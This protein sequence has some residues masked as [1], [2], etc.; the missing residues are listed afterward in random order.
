MAP[1][2]R[3]LREDVDVSYVDDEGYLV[4]AGVPDQTSREEADAWLAAVRSGVD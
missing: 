2:T 1:L 3:A 4:L